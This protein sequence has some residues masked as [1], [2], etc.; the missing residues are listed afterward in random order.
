MAHPLGGP[1]LSE[2]PLAEH[3]LGEKYAGSRHVGVLPMGC[4]QC[5]EGA[6]LV[7]FITGLKFTTATNAG[8]LMTS[9]PVFAAGAAALMGIER[10]TA[11]RLAG[12]AL[13]VAGALVLVN[14][15]R[16]SA[17]RSGVDPAVPRVSGQ[18]E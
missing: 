14:P 3:G 2:K 4:I 5:R 6:K 17:G 13:S 7:L 9:I 18:L 10:I 16:F 1:T 12:I 8:I 15:F 11:H